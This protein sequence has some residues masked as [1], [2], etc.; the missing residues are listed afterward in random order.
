MNPMENPLTH[1]IMHKKKVF[2]FIIF[3]YVPH[4]QAYVTNNMNHPL[5]MYIQK[6]ISLIQIQ[7]YYL[8]KEKNPQNPQVSKSNP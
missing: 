3:L 7:S 4:D 8:E 6:T 2:F 5:V 1:T